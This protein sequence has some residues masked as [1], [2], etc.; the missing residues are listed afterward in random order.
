[1]LFEKCRQLLVS[2]ITLVYY[3][4]DVKED[5]GLDRYLADP[6]G[7]RRE[8]NGTALFTVKDHFELS[9][10]IVQI[11][12]K[13][14]AG[15]LRVG[16]RVRTADEPPSLTIA[17]IDFIDQCSTHESWIGISFLER[18]SKELL[19]RAFPVGSMVHAESD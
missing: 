17:G 8:N 16:M 18:P 19:K 7:Y 4:K 13:I 5:P 11:F 2:N 6:K 10:H 9:G 3:H 14:R 15:T 12:G 1:M